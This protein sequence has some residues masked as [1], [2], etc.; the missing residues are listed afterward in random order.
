MLTD[1][2]HANTQLYTSKDFTLF[3]AL[4]SKVNRGPD[5]Y[6]EEEPDESLGLIALNP[7]YYYTL[8]GTRPT[9]CAAG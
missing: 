9:L 2:K 5:K 4:V 1:T 6:S 7:K 8:S 3:Y